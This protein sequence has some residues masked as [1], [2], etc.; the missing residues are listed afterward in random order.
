MMWNYAF[1]NPGL[2]IIYNN[3]KY[4]SNNGLK[5]LLDSKLES[6]I[7]YPIVHLKGEDIEIALSHSKL[8]YGETYFSFV[9][10]QH[11]TQGGTHQSSFREAI[12]KTLR[13]FYGKNFEASDIRQSI[14]AA[15]SIK[16]ME[17]VFESQTKTKLG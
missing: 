13:E 3:Q 14:V 11:T 7:V 12:V 2:T 1:L 5:D 4:F 6:S 9:N 17:P 8:K 15:I 10:G 16:V